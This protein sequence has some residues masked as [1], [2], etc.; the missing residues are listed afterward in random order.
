MALQS[1]RKKAAPDETELKQVDKLLDQT[2][3]AGLRLYRRNR[4][5]QSTQS[6]PWQTLSR[7]EQEQLMLKVLEMVV[8]GKEPPP[9]VRQTLPPQAL[10]LVSELLQEQAKLT[11]LGSRKIPARLQSVVERL[12]ARGILDKPS[13]PDSPLD[14]LTPRQRRRQEAVE[15]LELRRQNAI[16][17]VEARKLLPKQQT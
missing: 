6:R 1:K 16:Q 17:M 7:E 8:H 10:Q 14:R 2:Q 11:K 15:A 3:E 5:K 4:R 13:Q 9:A 12:Q